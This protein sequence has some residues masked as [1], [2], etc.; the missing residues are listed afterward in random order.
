MRH[1]FPFFF[2]LF[3]FFDIFL[4]I[5]KSQCYAVLGRAICLWGNIWDISEI[6]T[7]YPGRFNP[8]ICSAKYTF[9]LSSVKEVTLAMKMPKFHSWNFLGSPVVRNLPC[10]A[11]DLGSIPGRGTEIPHALEQQSLHAATAELTCQDWRESVRH[12]GDLA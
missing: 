10:N 12:R 8:W 5:K 11:M 2:F 3:S 4:G 7:H 1:Y 9:V 6:C